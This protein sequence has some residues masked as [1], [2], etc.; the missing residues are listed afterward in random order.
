MSPTDYLTAAAV[1]IWAAKLRSFLTSLGIIIGVG[2]VVLM[3]SV[4]AGVS[5]TVT[6]TFSELG[7]ARLTVLPSAP[8]AEPGHGGRGQG[9]S[10]PTASTLTVEDAAALAALPDVAASAPLIQVSA[11]VVGPAAAQTIAVSGTTP[12]YPAAATQKL[13]SGR[14]FASGT[15]AAVNAD[16]VTALYG[17]AQ[18]LGSKVQ[19]NGTPYTVVGVLANEIS[20][21]SQGTRDNPPALR[22]AA[23]IPVDQ[24]L[25]MAGTTKV[26]QILIAA[27]SPEVVQSVDARVGDEL[28]R[29]HGV[30]DFSVTSLQ[31]VLS[32][33]NQVF[34]VLTLFLAAIAGISLLV[35]GIG[36]M[37]IMLV[38]VTE[39]TREIGISK[40]IGATT[41]NVVIQFLVESVALSLLGGA[42]GLAVA[43]LGTVLLKQTLDLPSVVTPA[44]V[45]LAL[46]VSAFIGVFFGVVPAWRAAR[47]DPITALRHE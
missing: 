5:Q 40:A 24:A 17:G 35:G 37:N 15:E 36:I 42:L 30:R 10:P 2:A 20:P 25:R 41:S 27:R 43:W 6:G 29:R 21:F 8:N 3:M 19:V 28:A 23:Y 11:K 13:T 22:P 9:F 16:A 32:S 44:A 39:R 34:N 26:S 18:P 47:L 7:T 12:A 31:Q 45:L 38:S 1:D 46:G 33:F 4:G 14:M